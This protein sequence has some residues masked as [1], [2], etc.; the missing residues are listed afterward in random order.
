LLG[1]EGVAAGERWSARGAVPK[2][3]GIVDQTGEAANHRFALVRLEE[4]T[5]GI[6]SL[7]AVGMGEQTCVQ[8][9]LYFYGDAAAKTVAADEPAWRAWM[10][11]RFPLPS[12]A[13]KD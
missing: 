9:T 6:G 13:G 11:Q 10:A 12:S 5:Q 4:P 3:A 8:I 2:L 1:I 7:G